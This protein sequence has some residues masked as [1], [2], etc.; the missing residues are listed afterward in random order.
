M[1]FIH[2]KSCE[3]HGKVALITPETSW[4]FR[5]VPEDWKK[6]NVTPGFN[7]DNKNPGNY[8]QFTLISVFGK[9]EEPLSVDGGH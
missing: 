2:E 3:H 4:K 5:E 6:E 8:Q 7:K 1:R 9:D